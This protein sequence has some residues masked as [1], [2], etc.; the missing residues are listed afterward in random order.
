RRGCASPSW[1]GSL[2]GCLLG[3]PVGRLLLRLLECVGGRGGPRKC[4][5][6]RRLERPSRLLRSPR[7]ERFCGLGLL[8]DHFPVGQI[9]ELRDSLVAVF[10]DRNSAACVEVV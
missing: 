5:F 10:G 1:Q 4:C 6:K 7:V 2:T 8:E 9:G 3:E